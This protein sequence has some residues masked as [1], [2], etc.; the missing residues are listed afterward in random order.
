MTVPPSADVGPLPGYV[1]PPPGY[2]GPPPGYTGPPPGYTGPPPGYTGPP[3]GYVGPPPGYVG[4]PPGYVG[5]PPGYVGPPPHPRSPRTG[6]RDTVTTAISW[7]G[8][9][10]LIV[11]LVFLAVQAVEHNWLGPEIAVTVGAVLC[12]A[13]AAYALYNHHRSPHGPVAPALLTVAVIG[14]LSDIWVMVFGLGWIAPWAGA[15][16]ISLT[17]GLALGVARWWEES[18]LAF[19]LILTGGLFLTPAAVWLIWDAGDTFV[20]AACLLALGIL[21]WASTW[22]RNWIAVDAASAMVFTAGAFT[23]LADHPVVLVTC[24]ALVAVLTVAVLGLTPTAS[25]SGTATVAATVTRW[26]PASFIPVVIL[27]IDYGANG[28]TSWTLSDTSFSLWCAL[29]VTVVTC[30]VPVAFYFGRGESLRPP[31]RPEPVYTIPLPPLPPLP[32][33]TAADGAR[34]ALSAGLAGAVIVTTTGYATSD[35]TWWLCALVLTACVVV[36]SSPVLPPVIPWLFGSVTVL[37]GLHLLSPAWNRHIIL[38]RDPSWL[39]LVL[40]AVLGAVTVYRAEA[41]GTGQATRIV[42]GGVLLLLGASAVPLIARDIA[43]TDTSFMVGHLIVSVLWM[44]TGVIFLLRVDA[45]IGL[46]IAVLATAKLVLYDLSALDGLIQVAAF[47]LCGLILLGSAAL[48]ERSQATTGAETGAVEDS[49]DSSDT[50]A[51]ADD[52]GS[53]GMTRD[54]DDQSRSRR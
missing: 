51:S 43:N 38:D 5:P 6:H 27:C 12:L 31:P 7:L 9:A 24:A 52:Q 53:P 44:L 42:G 4:P 19:L 29:A 33:A 20:E 26:I 50:S 28:I 10:I 11:G 45:R 1:G 8:A 25:S 3:P 48:R 32:A 15:L 22:R 46:G 49:P 18:W 36:W 17:C 21:G 39:P 35:W 47:I 2:T 41:L 40:F 13:L 23:S 30:A 37:A 34:A 16:L 14:L 54:A